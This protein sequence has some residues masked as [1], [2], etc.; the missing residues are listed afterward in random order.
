MR[1]R[2]ISGSSACA[3]APRSRFL[4]EAAATLPMGAIRA[5]HHVP[6]DT[7]AAMVIDVFSAV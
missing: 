5:T 3:F 7:L 6:P 4:S 2:S 1:S